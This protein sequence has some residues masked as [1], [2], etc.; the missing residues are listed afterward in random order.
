MGAKY[1]FVTGGVVSS[2][3]KGITAAS[4]GRLLKARGY[5]VTMQKMDPY[6]N[7]DPGLLSPLQHGEAFITDD[8]VAADLDLG[9]YERFT[10]LALCGRASVTTGKIHKAI[11]ERELNGEYKGGTVQVIPHVTN[12]IKWRIR[13]NAAQ[14]DADIAI[15]EIGGTVGDMEGAPY[16]EAIRQMG[17]EEGPG[18]CCFIHLTLLPFIGAS[19]ELKTKPTQHSVKELRSIGI[20]PNILVCR[21]NVPISDEAKE[22]MALFCNVKPENVISNRDVSVLYEVPLMLESEGLAD[23]VLRELNLEA[24]KGDLTAWENLVER[25]KHPKRRIRIGLA[26]KY[27]ALPDAYLSVVEALTHAAIEHTIAVDIDWI[28]PEELADGD[29]HERLK[30]LDGIVVPGG[31]GKRGANEI[32]EAIHCARTEK[33]PFLSIGYGMQLT[34]VEAARYLLGYADANS[35]EVDTNTTH[36]VVRVPKDR[37]G[38]NDS[39]LKSRMG[40]QTLFLDADSLLASCY[41]GAKEISERHGNRY[42]V[43]NAYVSLLKEKGIAF[44]ASEKT[45]GYPEAVEIRNHPFYLGVIFHPEYKSRPDRAHPVFAA[46]IAAALKYAEGKE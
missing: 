9:H 2:L 20:Q 5:R 46:F 13:D 43:N 18:N 30:D 45:E 33:I 23:I 32:I 28:H 24:R 10:D 22:K 12:E 29:V 34:V 41:G 37:V 6:Y 19:K 27:A 7:V 1:V 16:L 38:A 31:Y 4:L 14:S 42:E 40:A 26:G 3:G 39:R 36:P 11:M 15:I 35:T 25:W 8:G 21:S 44:P 17:W